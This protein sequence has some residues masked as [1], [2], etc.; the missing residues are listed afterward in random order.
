ML[1]GYGTHDTADR[2]YD[3]AVT[4]DDA[5]DREFEDRLLETSTLAFRVAYSV[6]RHREDASGEV[7]KIEVTLTVVK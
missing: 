4:A 6:L 7:L 3:G 1:G 2:V 5:L